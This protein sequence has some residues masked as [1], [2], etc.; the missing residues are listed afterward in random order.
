[1]QIS[2]EIA[3]RRQVYVDSDGRYGTFINFPASEALNI[4]T[5][6]DR[7]STTA[8][9]TLFR[10]VAETETINPKRTLIRLNIYVAHA[11]NTTLH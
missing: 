4:D 9:E 7:D 6:E 3:A 1:M 11:Y 2:K 5:Y 10:N 8:R